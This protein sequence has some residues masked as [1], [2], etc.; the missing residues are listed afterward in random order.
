MTFC[1][2]SP[3]LVVRIF[4]AC[5][6]SRF[7][8]IC[9]IVALGRTNK[10]LILPFVPLLMFSCTRTL[11]SGSLLYYAVNSCI[12]HHHQFLVIEIEQSPKY[13]KLNVYCRGQS[14]KWS[15]L[16]SMLWK[17]QIS[18]KIHHSL[19]I[20]FLLCCLGNFSVKLPSANYYVYCKWGKSS[21]FFV[22]DIPYMKHLII[23]ICDA[24][25]L[26]CET[27][28]NCQWWLIFLF[29]NRLEINSM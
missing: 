19:G 16:Y 28:G 17:L 7:S 10:C 27:W 18:Y 20:Q 5:K 3:C 9:S 29:F 13:H 8:S 2:C 14:L 1:Y 26:F 23:L 12:I 11:G 22:T 15:P 6:N 24:Q 21:Y 4:N 25:F